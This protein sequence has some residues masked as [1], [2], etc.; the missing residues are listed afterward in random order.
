MSTEVDLLRF[1]HKKIRALCIKEYMLMSGY[2]RAV[3]FS[4]GNAAHALENVGVDVLHIGEHGV[5]E[6]KQWFS[7]ADIEKAFTGYF[8]ATSGHLPMQLMNG[9]AREYKCVLGALPGRVYVPCGSGETLVCLKMAYPETDFVAV[10][11]IDSATQYEAGCVLNDLVRL[12]ACEV[13]FMNREGV[14]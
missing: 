14:K 8:D 12:L 6:P 5:L 9:L 1:P 10:Y 7:Q 3:C 13:V 2:K 11:N 4:C